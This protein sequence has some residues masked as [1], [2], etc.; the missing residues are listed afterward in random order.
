LEAL[1]LLLIPLPI[2]MGSDTCS[3]MPPSAGEVAGSLCT[4][5]LLIRLDPAGIDATCCL[6]T[7]MGTLLDAPNG[8]DLMADIRLEVWVALPVPLR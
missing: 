5:M 6:S 7:A 4:E 2:G 8:A 1:L 3:S